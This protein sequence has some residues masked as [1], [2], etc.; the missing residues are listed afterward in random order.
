MNTNLVIGEELLEASRRAIEIK[1]ALRKQTFK[2]YCLQQIQKEHL[3]AAALNSADTD[4]E[5]LYYE[6]QQETQL[7]REYQKEMYDGL[8]F[9]IAQNIDLTP[10]ED[11]LDS[12]ADVDL[13]DTKDDVQT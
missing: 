12:T 4:Y 3:R 7:G 8:L 10:E 9:L 11:D 13:K 5:R 1:L 6:V 2:E